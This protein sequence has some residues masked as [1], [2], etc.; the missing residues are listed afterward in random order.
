MSPLKA[1]AFELFTETPFMRRIKGGLLITEIVDK[2]FMKQ[3]G[4]I[5]QNILIYSGHDATLANMVRGLNISDQAPIMPEYGTSLIFE[6]HCNDEYSSQIPHCAVKVRNNFRA[7][8]K[9]Q[10]RG[11]IFFSDMVLFEYDR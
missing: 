2:M 11:D 8:I 1:R 7:P 3:S 4:E 6:M 10:L 5:T 9:M